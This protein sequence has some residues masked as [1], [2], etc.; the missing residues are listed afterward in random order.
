MVL[1]EPN[2]ATTR[3]AVAY[4]ILSYFI[5]LVYLDRG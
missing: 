3:L 2:K 4:S 1:P 5:S